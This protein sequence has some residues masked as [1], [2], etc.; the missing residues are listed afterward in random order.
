MDI[1]I[2]NGTRLSGYAPGREPRAELYRNDGAWRFT[3]VGRAAGVAHV[4]WGMGVTAADYNADGWPDLYLANYGPNALYEN[5]GDGTFVDV[6]AEQ[7]VDFSGW[8]S[9][10]A[11]GDY[12]LDGDL[13]FYLANYIDFDP[14]FRPVD[15][16]YCN[17]ARDRRILRPAR[18][19]GRKGSILSQRRPECGLDFYR[20]Q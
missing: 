16:S 19:A 14:A 5:E 15:P 9:S 18:D 10:A 6:A 1:F 11:F 4:G 8:S 3:G 2:V 17:L 13:D 7:G 20:R 12:D